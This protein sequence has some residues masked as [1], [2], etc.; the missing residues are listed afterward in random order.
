MKKQFFVW[1][2]LCLMLTMV[3]CS[4]EE[5]NEEHGIQKEMELG[6]DHV[7]PVQTKSTSAATNEAPVS[8]G[9][10]GEDINVP[11]DET[12]PEPGTSPETGI[13]TS[14]GTGNGDDDDEDKDLGGI[15]PTIPKK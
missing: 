3:S 10:G 12:N 11:D 15:K 9:E 14:P 1:A 8:G 5:I 13:G 2:T 4:D 6:K 7:L